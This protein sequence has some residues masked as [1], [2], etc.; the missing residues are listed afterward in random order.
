M[1]QHYDDPAFSYEGYWSG[2]GYEQQA[3]IMALKR[4]FFGQKFYRA[5]D[6]GGG[7]GRLTVLLKQYSRQTL[8]IEPS[9][10]QRR[11]AR[12][13]LSPK[14]RIA[15]LPGQVQ[16]T[17]LPP[18]S[19]D[20][21]LLVRVMHHLPDPSAAFREI[22]RILKPGKFL[23]LEF[24]NSFHFKS[25]LLSFVTGQPILLTPIERRSPANIKKETIPFVNHHPETIIKLL[26][27]SGF[28]PVKFLSVS[29]LR[30]PRIKQ[31]LPPNWLIALEYAFQPLL[32]SVFFGPSIFVLA[33]KNEIPKKTPQ[34]L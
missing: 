33:R 12:K 13:Y 14:S 32:S 30:Y 26:T 9:V 22:H 31:F 18:A 19:L 11:L 16:K 6:I 2:R 1:P 5:A 29:N 15:I 4:L 28:T 10:K 25:R 23:V 24:A 8:L 17:N 3:E 27:R 21:V 7:F 20:L 34:N